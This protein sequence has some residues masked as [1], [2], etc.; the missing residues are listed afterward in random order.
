MR[1]YKHGLENMEKRLTALVDEKSKTLQK[2]H[3]NNWKKSYA[4]VLSVKPVKDMKIQPGAGKEIKHDIHHNINERF[5]IQGIT[6][7]PE[8]SKG[9]NFAPQPKKY[10]KY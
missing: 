9:E 6:E 5:R 10:M 8:K 1:V 2:L 3:A 4:D 7:D